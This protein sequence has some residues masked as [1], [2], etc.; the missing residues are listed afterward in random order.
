MKNKI[1]A[2]LLALTLAL[3]LTACGSKSD[4]SAKADT[5]DDAQTEQPAESQETVTLNVAASPTPHAEI[6]KQCVPILA[7]QGIDLQIT[8]FDDYVMP[9]TAVEDGSLDANY[10]Q[11]L[12]Y[13]EDFNA[14]N[15]THLASVGVIHYE[16]MGLYP[17]KSSDL[18]NIPDGAKIGIPG[19]NT[20]GARALLLLEA[21][22][23]LKLKEGV[24]LEATELDIEEN[25]HN[26]EIVPM[27]AANLPASLPDLDFAVINGNYASGI[28]DTVLVTEDA[29]SVAAQT[30]G[31]IVAV[32]EGN[33]NNPAVL[34]LVE[35][36]KS[37]TIKQYIKDNY[38]GIVMPME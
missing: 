14:K 3:S 25:P 1:F 7:E 8:E 6:L 20:N 9:N 19:D 15:G 35:A 29:D 4:D 11:H 17:G 16:P 36:L 21:Q 27:E 33:E 24:G 37:D 28:A 18:A 13:L 32:K 12:P 5:T 38:N 2:T 23:V 34:A 30:Y 22:G 10:F 31:N 26:V